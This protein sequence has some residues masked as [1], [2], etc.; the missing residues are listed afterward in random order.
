MAF[1]DVNFQKIS[2]EHAPG[3]S[4]ALFV[5]QLASN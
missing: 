3:P 2:G 4:G 5:P 1:T